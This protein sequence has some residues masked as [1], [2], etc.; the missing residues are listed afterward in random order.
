VKSHVNESQTTLIQF[1][2]EDIKIT[3]III[4]KV[5]EPKNDGSLGSRPLQYSFPIKLNPPHE[6]VSTFIQKWNRPFVYD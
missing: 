4:E 3:N 6:W 2:K 5:T 1:P